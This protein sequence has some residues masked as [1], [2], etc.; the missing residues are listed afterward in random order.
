[1]KDE[2]RKGGVTQVIGTGAAPDEV[3]T[4]PPKEELHETGTSRDQK[5][6]FVKHQRNVACNN[7]LL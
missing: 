1:M 6:L 7:S 4:T 2:S 5:V 3:K